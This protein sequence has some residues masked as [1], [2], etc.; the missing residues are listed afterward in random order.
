[1]PQQAGPHLPVGEVGEADECLAPDPEQLEA[2][3]RDFADLLFA[4]AIEVSGPLPQERGEFPDYAR[5]VLRF[6]RREM[7][8]LRALVDALN[9]MVPESAPPPRDAGPLE[10]V[11]ASLPPEAES[12][13]QE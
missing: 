10:V 1:M 8:R 5:L 7:G 13:E 6:D 3:N 9:D 12:A 11:E 2:L 4:G